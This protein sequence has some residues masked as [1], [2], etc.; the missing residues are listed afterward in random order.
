MPS[1]PSLG[2]G[3]SQVCPGRGHPGAQVLL[4]CGLELLSE[5]TA[6]PPHC[7]QPRRDGHLLRRHHAELG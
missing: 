2:V 5:R 6:P 7:P 3:G 4:L 1:V